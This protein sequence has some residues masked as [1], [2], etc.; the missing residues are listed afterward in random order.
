[1]VSN[2]KKYSPNLN[3]SIKGTTSNRRSKRLK[4]QGTKDLLS[5]SNSSSLNDTFPL[6]SNNDNSQTTSC[7]N[8]MPNISTSGPDFIPVSCCR[9]VSEKPYLVVLSNLILSYSI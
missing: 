8:T 1:M 3:V 5:L 4:A 7:T 6:C 2:F 9:F